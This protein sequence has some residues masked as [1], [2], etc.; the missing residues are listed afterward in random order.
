M[1]PSLRPAPRARRR[2]SERLPHD[3][4]P[5]D[6]GGGVDEHEPPAHPPVPEREQPQGGLLP[7]DRDPR[8]RA[9]RDRALHPGGSI[10][11]YVP[12]YRF[13]I[14]TKARELAADPHKRQAG[15]RE[16]PKQQ[17]DRYVLSEIR[18]ELSTFDWDPAGRRSKQPWLGVV[19]D[20]TVW[21]AWL[22][23]HDDNPAIETLSAVAT[24][25]AAGLLAA[26]D[27]AFARE[28]SGKPVGAG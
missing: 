15:D 13:I 14:E 6:P 1:C 7:P 28:R 27:A 22:Y 5:D 25:D 10:D 16:S 4:Q 20:G 12:H 9:G 2:Q 23:P 24:L 17:L 21:H 11:I 8:P 26:L 19:T 3:R 18:T